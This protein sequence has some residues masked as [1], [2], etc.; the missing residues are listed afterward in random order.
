MFADDL[1]RGKIALVTGAS[2]GLGRHFAGLLAAHGAEVAL[3][4]RQID[5]LAQATEEL[6][7]AGARTLPVQMDVRDPGSISDAMDEAEEALGPLD[8]LVNN[9]GIALTAPFAEHNLGDLDAVI[10]TNLRGVFLVGQEAAKRMIPRGRGSIVNIA[11][12]AG[13]KVLGQL[14]SYCAT[15]AAV[16]HLTRSMAVELARHNIRVNALAPGYV[17]TA[18]NDDFF[19]TPAGEKL[20]ARVPQRRL[21]EAGELD[22][23][24]LLLASDAGS[25]ATGSILTVDGGLSVA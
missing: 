24:L 19:A 10:D 22:A 2:Q 25:F 14:S 8:I 16:E 12:I 13:H 20:I 15:K 7:A 1:L 11:S 4:A 21:G 23:A 5:K 18:I 17:R 9:A 3:A 6:A